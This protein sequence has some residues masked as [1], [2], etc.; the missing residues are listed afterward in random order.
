MNPDIRLADISLRRSLGKCLINKYGYYQSIIIRDCINRASCDY[1]EYQVA[2]NKIMDINNRT[3][4]NKSVEY[5]CGQQVSQKKTLAR[6]KANEKE[7]HEGVKY[8]C[9]HCDHQATT[10]G[11]LARHKRAVHEGVKYSCMQ[12]N[13]QA[14]TKGNLAQHKREIHEG[15]KYACRQC[16]H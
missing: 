5:I 9:R 7:I 10:K 16:D 3:F 1:C 2:S 6:H 14:T 11:S 13:H 12:C 8:A 15:V 4:H